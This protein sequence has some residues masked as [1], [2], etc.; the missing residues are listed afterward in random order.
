M[1]ATAA[2]AVTYAPSVH[3]F[4][5]ASPDPQ[6]WPDPA[7][8]YFM[9]AFDTSGSMTGNASNDSNSCGITSRPQSRNSHGRCAL[10][11]TIQAFSEVRFGLAGYATLMDDCSSGSCTSPTPGSTEFKS[12]CNYYSFAG[13]AAGDSCSDGCGPEPTALAFSADRR[14]SNILVPLWQDT[15]P[16][17]T[18]NTSELLKWVDNDCTNSEEL[19]AAGCTPLNGILRDMHRYFSDEWTRPDGAVTHES[20]LTSTALGE[21]SCRSLNVILITDGLETCDNN[22]NEQ[23][24]ESGG[25]QAASDAAADLLSGF[26]KDGIS[27]SV[28]THVIDFA[29]GC[30]DATDAIAFAGGTGSAYLATDETT[31]S[32]ALANIISGAI[33]PEVCDNTDNNCNTCVDEGY[34]H[35]CNISQTCCDWDNENERQACLTTYKA[36]ITAGDPDGDTSKLPCTTVGEA[37]SSASWLCFDPGDECDDVDNNCQSGTD[38]NSTKCGTPEHCP[39][40]ETCDGIDNDCDGVTDESCPFCVPSAEIC[41][42]C[43]NDC[44]G[45]A[46]DGVADVACGLAT[47]ANC[48]G[49]QS[50]KAAQAVPVGTCAAGNSGYNA[51]TNSPEAE[52]CDGIDNDCD[53]VADDGLPSTECVPGTAPGGLIYGGTSQCKKGTQACNGSCTGFV[54]PSA[55]ICDGVDNDCDGTVDEGIGVVGLQCGISNAPC[56]PGLTAC[57]GGALVCQGGVGPDAEVCDGADN[58]CDGKVDEAPLADAPSSGNN[59]CWNEPGNCCSYGTLSWCPPAGGA[60]VGNGTLAPPCNRGTLACDGASGWI[61]QGDKGPQPEVCDGVDN[62]CDGSPDDGSLAGIGDVCGDDTGECQAGLTACAGGIITCSGEI[63]VATELCDGLDNDC[64]GVIDNDI[65]TGGACT[66]DYD[67]ALYPG[68]RAG[69]PCQPGVLECDGAGGLT[70]VGGLGPNPELCDGVDNDCDGNVDETGTAPDGINGSENPFPPPDGNIGDACGNTSGGDDCAAGTYACVNGLFA[71]LGSTTAQPETCDCNDN[72]CDGSV[73]EGAIC[74]AG[75]TCIGFGG[76]CFCAAQCASGEFKCP[77]TQACEKAVSSETQEPAG[78]FCIDDPCGDCAAKTMTAPGTG[79]VLC[80]PAGTTLAGCEQVPECECKGQAGC[81]EPCYGVTCDS[82]LVCTGFGANAGKCAVDNCYNLPCQGCDQACHLG[83]CLENPCK[84]DTCPSGEVCKPSADFTSHT[85]VGSCAD[86]TCPSGE[87]CVDGACVANCPAC[88]TG[89]VCDLTADPPACVQNQCTETSCPDGSC[90]NPVNGECGDCPCEGIT[91]PDGQE[92]KAGECFFKSTSSA[93]GGGDAGGSN[94]GT[95]GEDVGPSGGTGAKDPG[96]TTDNGIW[97]LTTGGGGCACSLSEATQSPQWLPWL[98]A[99]AAAMLGRRRGR[100]EASN[101]RRSPMAT[102]GLAAVLMSL[103]GCTTEAFCFYGCGDEDT[104]SSSTTDPSGSGGGLLLG[105]GGPVGLGGDLGIGGGPTCDSPNPGIEICDGFDNDCDGKTDEDAD[106]TQPATCGTC[107]N[108][109]FAQLANCAPQE[110]VCTPSG[111]G[112]GTCSCEGCSPDYYDLDN[113]GLSCEYYC[114]KSANDDSL[115]NNKDDDCDGNKDEDVNLCSDANNC[116]KC[117]GKCTVLH[118]SGSC[119]N[120]GGA[121]CGPGNTS[122]QIQSCTCNGTECWW[123]LDGSYATGCEYQCKLT[124]GGVEICDGIDN[125]CDGKIDAF[126]SLAGDPDIGVPCYGGTEG[127]CGAPAY[128]GATIC[129]AGQVQCDGVN[130][131]VPG[132]LPEVCDGVDNDCDGSV[133]ENAVDAG[134]QC[135]ASNIFPCSFGTNQCVAGVLQCAGAVSPGVE[136][137]D[138]QD[139]DCDGEIDATAGTP[140]SDAFGSCNEPPAAPVGGTTPCKAGLLNC[141]GGNLVCQGSLEAESSVDTCGVDANCSGVLENQPDKTSDANN[142]GACGNVCK[143]AGTHGV[144]TCSSSTC[145]FQGCETGYHDIANDKKCSYACIN[146]GAEVCDGIDNDCDGSVDEGVTAPLPVQVC[147]TSPAATRAEC[148]SQVTVSCVA[149]AWSCSFPNNVCNGS[150]G[151]SNTSEIC[152]ALDNDCDGA[153]NENVANFGQAC[154]SD[155]GLPAPGHGACRTVGTFQCSGTSG[156]TCSAVPSSCSSLPGGCTELCD[157]VDNDCDGSIDEPFTSKGSVSGFYVKPK[158]TKVASSTWIYSYEA[159]RPDAD[160]A[161]PGSGNGFHTSAPSGTTLDKT[162]S[163]SEPSRIPWFNVTPEEA[164]QTC[165]AAGGHICSKSEWQTACK[166]DTS[167]TYGYAPR[168]AACV[169]A[170]TASKYC[171][172]HVSF[173]FS[174]DPGVQEGLLPSASSDLQNCW[175]D[176]SSKLGNSTANSKIYD[177][178]GNLREIT[179]T[180]STVWPL[181]GGAMNTQ[182]EGGAACDFDFYAV[183]EEFKL[184]DVGFRCCFSTDPR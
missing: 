180:S 39:S 125:D 63:G 59:G 144:W 118:G 6:D 68:T 43:D 160:D 174:S 15:V 109:C 121:P 128:V 60:C 82:P 4:D 18:S 33:K 20:P 86:V 40:T 93:A 175:A 69:A 48:V 154:A 114:A 27:W 92:C 1:F 34:R 134:T 78:S 90:C 145:A 31:L 87:T 119:V 120:T 156:V 115:C 67:T 158:V 44:D 155:D 171:N 13:E 136:L 104:T 108:N 106:F 42:G 74:G 169:A 35:Y 148:T 19:W 84:A 184:F 75:K 89:Q 95:G 7:R 167:C 123:D 132:E 96:T 133:D 10:R 21:R 61:C 16:P 24:C 161:D 153:L 12:S 79:D 22:N 163:C 14:G 139:N 51:C 55:E 142:C 70:C 17:G 62:D 103:S 99:L 126:D 113:D 166:A 131:V 141:V 45:I 80:A 11:K 73:D 149:G 9:I 88:P 2:A 83:S 37:A 140:P 28:K 58:D 110:V 130:V 124:N 29:S 151:C 101:R 100:L 147:G 116:G 72:D 117:G 98:G 56:S 94:P 102:V 26:T 182:A 66:P 65:P 41:D 53:G 146:T 172:M 157:D 77:G 152:D 137:C 91:C 32:Q 46:D 64:D 97:G 143:A 135:G 111:S 105:G 177:I 47:P 178:T 181:M 76:T 168:G 25:W 173:D 57:V 23:D 8:P 30:S 3:A 179:K 112:A 85:C 71:C 5:C 49:T 159:S 164:E 50:C 138:G 38:E 122:C 129:A 127:Q 162:K 107:A 36:T 54:G 52:V 170:F 183:D 150:S 165:A 176:W 81:Q